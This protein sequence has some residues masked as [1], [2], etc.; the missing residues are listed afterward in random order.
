MDF[1]DLE[2]NFQSQMAEEPASNA[3]IA[4]VPWK[5]PEL[6]ALQSCTRR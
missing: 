5:M 3:A 6:A 2:F 4:N 1:A